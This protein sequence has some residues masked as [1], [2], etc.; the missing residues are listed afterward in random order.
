MSVLAPAL[1]Q[2]GLQVL[3]QPYGG[4][5]SQTSC[6]LAGVIY[7]AY[8]SFK[9]VQVLTRRRTTEEAEKWLT[10]WAVYASFSVV[11]RLLDKALPWLPWYNTLKF[12]FILWLQLPR[13]QA[14]WLGAQRL[15]RELILP[16]L[17][18]AYPHIENFL[19][20]VKISL[21]QPELQ[22]AGEHINHLLSKVPLLEWFVRG[23]DGEPVHPPP[24]GR[25]AF[26]TDTTAG[27][28]DDGGLPS[29]PA[30]GR[31]WGR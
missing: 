21:G 1:T 4:F 30:A 29:A 17:A 27:G 28:D 2:V 3:L 11:E 23:P 19:T 18:Q 13:Y 31:R 7:P 26:I 10:Y 8:A 22:A 5:I 24:P 15:Y 9:A 12:A 25:P 14:R 16:P 6:T 20:A